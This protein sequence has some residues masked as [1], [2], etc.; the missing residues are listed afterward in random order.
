MIINLDFNIVKNFPHLEELIQNHYFIKINSFTFNHHCYENLMSILCLSQKITFRGMIL[1]KNDCISCLYRNNDNHLFIAKGYRKRLRI[2]DISE[3]LLMIV[4]ESLI[5]DSFL[6]I[7][8]NSNFQFTKDLNLLKFL[9][10]LIAKVF[11]ENNSPINFEI[12]HQEKKIFSSTQ[13][14]LPQNPTFY[15]TGFEFQ[16]QD[17]KIDFEVFPTLSQVIKTPSLQ[18]IKQWK[19]LKCGNLLELN[20]FQ[21]F[22]GFFNE[23]L[24]KSQILTPSVCRSC[25]EFSIQQ[26]CRSCLSKKSNF[27][28]KCAA[29][30]EI[31]VDYYLN[32]NFAQVCRNCGG[33]SEYELCF[34]CEKKKFM[35]KVEPTC[36][37]CGKNSNEKI[38]KGCNQRGHWKCE[39]CTFN[40]QNSKICDSC[41]KTKNLRAKTVVVKDCFNSKRKRN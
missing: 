37:I 16:Q 26:L 1:R 24:K 12:D 21:C 8:N 38:C 23:N 20:S 15:K 31:G 28:K 18:M 13:D 32:C 7:P 2:D 39:Y 40:N 11:Q 5:P 6:L 27:C 25:G 17:K 19:C 9:P 36:E 3:A 34:E 33:F 10:K 4:E 41:H 14:F 29:Q 22:C 30:V 35:N